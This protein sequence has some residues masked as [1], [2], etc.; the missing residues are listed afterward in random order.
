[1]TGVK[2]GKTKQGQYL[3]NFDGFMFALTW[4]MCGTHQKRAGHIL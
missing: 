2:N 1:M 3:Y 4:E